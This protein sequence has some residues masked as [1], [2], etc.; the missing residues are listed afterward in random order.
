MEDVEL[1]NIIDDIYFIYDSVKEK[2]YKANQLFKK[3]QKELDIKCND[4]YLYLLIEYQHEV[5][6]CAYERTLN[7]FKKNKRANIFQKIYKKMVKNEFT[8]K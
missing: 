3:Y 8:K 5:C 4:E 7:Y 2:G 1:E 6:N